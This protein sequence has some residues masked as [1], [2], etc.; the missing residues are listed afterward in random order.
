[1]KNSKKFSYSTVNMTGVANHSAPLFQKMFRGVCEG[2][3]SMPG[4]N[5]RGDLK[6]INDTHPGVP[7][8]PLRN[9]ETQVEIF[10]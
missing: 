3:A 4:P 1:L 5:M 9:D 2:L 6:L 10:E 8:R 7:L